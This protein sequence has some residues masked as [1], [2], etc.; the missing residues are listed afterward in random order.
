MIIAWHCTKSLNKPKSNTN[1]IKPTGAPSQ[2]W[3]EAVATQLQRAMQ[4][5]FVVIFSAAPLPPPLGPAGAEARRPNVP[6]DMR[7]AAEAEMAI[8]QPKQ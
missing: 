1:D 3:D 4:L 2:T 6:V 5:N 7:R 8:W